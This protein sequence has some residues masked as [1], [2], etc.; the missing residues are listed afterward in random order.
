MD[1][2]TKIFIIGFNKTGTRTLHCFFKDNGLP[3]IHWDNNYLVEHFQENLWK[4]LPLLGR[5]RVFNKKRNTNCFYKDGVVFSDMTDLRFNKDPKDY[6]KIL[7]VQY[8]NSK[9]ILNFRDVNDWVK[10]RMNH[11]N[12]AERQ[13]K[14]HKCDSVENLQKIWIKM[15]YSHMKDCESYFQ[16]RDTDFLKFNLYE[17][18]PNE[19]CEFLK[20]YYP[21]LDPKKWK[22]KGVTSKK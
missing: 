17:D 16:G 7:D 18:G 10:S 8:P 5:K 12:L 21:H 20:D 9:F 6:Y 14:F 22:V 4:G 15:Y 19:I 13:M 2:K 11:G 1:Y 3:S